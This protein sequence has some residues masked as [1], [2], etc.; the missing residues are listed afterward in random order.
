MKVK[1]ILLSVIISILMTGVIYSASPGG[2]GAQI[3]RITPTARP[4]AMGDAFTAVS[5]D[6]NGLFFN[7]AGL[8]Y[9][10]DREVIF[11]HNA[12][13]GN[14]VYNDRLKTE[15]IAYAQPFGKIGA[16][17]GY[18]LYFREKTPGTV[19]KDGLVDYS[20]DGEYIDGDFVM[21]A[22][23]GRPL[24]YG[25]FGGANFKIISE[26]LDKYHAF[27]IA[28]D[29]GGLYTVPEGYGT[30]GVAI[31]NIGFSFDKFV[32]GHLVMPFLV[33]V[34]FLYNS[35]PNILHGYLQDKLITTADMEINF[36]TS[37][38]FSIML[39]AEYNYNNLIYPRIGYKLGGNIE[40]FDGLSMGFGA[41]YKWKGYLL[42][43]DYALM[44]QGQFGVD[45]RLTLGTKF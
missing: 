38:I 35:F 21:S 20:T 40:G 11:S 22:G 39:G 3:L 1:A 25:I 13:A 33:R 17:G 19:L 10:L 24:L 4:S 7:P 36:S 37:S 31:K 27:A 28:M 43:L 6:I 15:Y 14:F 12:F 42:N 9:I 26:R 2:T 30:I 45:Q 5:D 16:L 44:L 23:Y 8:N 29:L 41:K 18:L 32:K 34:G